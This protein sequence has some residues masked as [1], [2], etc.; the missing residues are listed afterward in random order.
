[1]SAAELGVNAREGA[2]H[3]SEIVGVAH[4]F[5]RDHVDNEEYVRRAEF[6]LGRSVE[7]LARESRMKT[8]RWC[9][10]EEDTRSLAEAAVESL[11][12]RYPEAC[13]DIDV[14]VVASGTT[15][16]FAHPS[17]REHRVFADLSPLVLRKLGLSRALGLDIK[18]CYCSGFVRGLAVMDG[19]LSNANYR[20]G[21]LLCVEQGSRF[22][23]AST[24]RSSFS[25]I[26][27][28]AAGAVL[29]KR[30]KPRERRGVI[31]YVGF[32]DV[33]KLEW[34]GI[35]DDAASIIMMGSRAADATRT[36]L[37]SCARTLL[38][39]NQLAPADVDWL[40]PIQTHRGLLDS[41]LA[42]LAF[43]ADKLMWRGDVHG[44]SGSASIPACLSEQY[45][46]GRIKKGDLVLSLAVGAG[47]NAGGSLYVV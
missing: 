36:M 15:I 8:R 21:L 5:P 44:F 46:A 3:T 9:R 42:E 40:L 7:E 34:V 17:D 37:I 20:Y 22:A 16:P 39:R 31:D 28:D 13:R 33:S 6:D 2:S 35:G 4:A 18:A 38:V 27:G 12:E 29:M 25:F 47:M 32:T 26:V 23:T 30:G 45:Q 1:M 43:P 14:V 19:L 24:N 11:S 41:V 10:P